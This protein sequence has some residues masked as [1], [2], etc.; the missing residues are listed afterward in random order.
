MGIKMQK[1]ATKKGQKK[2]TKGNSVIKI[3]KPR[4]ASNRAKREKWVS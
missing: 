1:G 2:I 4:G 3:K